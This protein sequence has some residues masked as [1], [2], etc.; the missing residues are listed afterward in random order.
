MKILNVSFFL[1]LLFPSCLYC[2][3]WKQ[4]V[5][6]AFFFKGQKNSEQTIKYYIMAKEILSRDSSLT[7]TY[8]QFCKDVGDIYYSL[9]HYKD[10]EPFYIEARSVYQKIYGKTGA[11]LSKTDSLG[12]LYILTGNY[13]RAEI[14]LTESKEIKLRL[15]SKR[16]AQYA[17]SCNILGNLYTEIGRYDQAEILLIEAKKIRE[18]LF[19][20]HSIAYAQSC[21]NLAAFYWSKGDYEK[22]EPL[23]LEARQIRADLLTT[24]HSDYAICCINL[25]NI[26]RDM[27]QYEKSESF[28]LE[29]KN[30]RE[31]VFTKLHSVYA[32]SCN[33]LA[34]LYLYMERYSE[35]ETLYLEA[36]NIR[37]KLFGKKSSQYAQTC[38]NLSGLYAETNDYKK[39]E[40]LA[41]EAKSIFDTI[42]PAGHPSHAINLN[43]LGK[44]Y[45][46]MGQFEVAKEYLSQARILWEKKI[47]K[48]HPYYFQNS[49]SLANVYW[50]LNE[51]IKAN[52]L[53]VESFNS[54]YNQINKIFQFTNEKEKQ[55][56]IKNIMS[57]D[58]EYQSFHYQNFSNGKAAFPYTLAIS[59][60]NLI[61]SSVQK[62]KQIIQTTRDTLLKKK[63]K[64][65]IFL[66]EQL[67]ALYLKPN[68]KI[69]QIKET[70][71]KANNIEKEI[72]LRS[73]AFKKSQQKVRWKDIQRSLNRNEAAIEF[74]DFVLSYSKRKTDSTYYFALLLRKDKPE[75]ILIPLFEKRSLQALFEETEKSSMQNINALYTRGAEVGNRVLQSDST[76][77]QLI[78][79]P[80][81]KYLKGIGKIYF[82]PAGLL[83][84]VAFAALPVNKHSV[85]SDKYKLVQLSNT[86]EIVNQQ[87]YYITSSD[88]IQLYGGIRYSVDSVA[89]KDKVIKYHSEKTNISRSLPDDLSRTETWNFLP[90]TE[91][92]I[93]NIKSVAQRK[94]KISI[95]SGINA[96]EESFKALDG[97]ASPAILHIA[98]HGFFFPDPK[99][100]TRRNLKGDDQSNVFKKSENP[101]IRSGILFAGANNA[102]SG[103]YI[104]GI[105][106]GILTGYEVSNLYLPNTKLVVLSACETGLG[107]IMGAEGVYGL[108]RAFKIAGAQNIVMS[109]WK[110]P[111]NETADFMH[112]FYKLMFNK[113]SI[114][115]AFYK[116]R[117]IMRNRFRDEPNKWAAWILVR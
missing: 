2:Q 37:E 70:E 94:N 111:D 78:W 56:Y 114:S 71:E 5:D 14:F 68:D 36:K 21:N 66:K 19:T 42:L 10:A 93:T 113:I 40:A 48:D 77:Y 88:Q 104:N 29:A 26:Y 6:S 92:E 102:W 4:Y 82:S 45:S 65:W 18:S 80:I 52:E 17:V 51:P 62:L 46:K 97:N 34:D 9:S 33:I 30:V 95:A 57:S 99:D 116:T 12:V 100:S 28:Y 64:D 73:S 15:F 55:S 41:L 76:L 39:A 84:K 54:Q 61:L 8:I 74:I 49:A 72:S 81:E 22:A 43:N 53:Y 101:L 60:R 103:N 83:H 20:K 23:A 87:P 107:D 115:D 86:Q 69:E 96:T 3:I 31:K 85:L 109:L 58:D 63:Y 79:Q 50:N 67:A 117:A 47:G 13:E 106:D 25:G 27:G 98:S 105:E 112:E 89:L 108:Q 110:V 11:Y 1:Y 24:A 38:N 75:P 91:K 59:N 7:D 44:L 32:S 35:A 16:S 90:G